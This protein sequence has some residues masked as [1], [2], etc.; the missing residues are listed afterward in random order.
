MR[1]PT[2]NSHP[3]LVDIHITESED[4]F[5][6]VLFNPKMFSYGSNFS[7]DGSNNNNNSLHSTPKLEIVDISPLAACTRGGRRVL[8]VVGEGVDPAQVEPVFRVL[9]RPHL[10]QVLGQPTQVTR[11]NSQVI[12]FTAPAQP[13]LEHLASRGE[14]VQVQVTVRSRSGQERQLVALLLHLPQAR[15][16][17][18]RRHGVPLLQQH[19]RLDL[20]FVNKRLIV[21]K[22]YVLCE[23]STFT[24]NNRYRFEYH[25]L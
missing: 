22:V 15:A 20:A 13:H 6:Q 7:T 2:A 17:P 5:K 14:Q 25:D 12:S 21:V 10:D 11:L 1:N 3:I 4:L 19:C 16:R 23:I 8:V 9:H 18:V 24:H